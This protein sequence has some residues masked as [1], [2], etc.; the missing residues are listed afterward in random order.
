VKIVAV[1][2]VT[3]DWQ[4]VRLSAGV[5]DGRAERA[6]LVTFDG[7]DDVHLLPRLA[8]TA[9][10]GTTRI[11]LPFETFTGEPWLWVT[12]IEPEP[13]GPLAYLVRVYYSTRYRRA[14]VGANPNPLTSP[15]DDPPDIRWTFLDT[16]EE[17]TTDI[18]GN[19][20]CNS[21]GVIFAATRPF[22]DLLLQV[23]FNRSWYDP[24][25]AL[26]FKNTVNLDWFL[27]VFPPGVV[28]CTD[29]SGESARAAQLMYWVASL[30]FRIRS[31]G[32]RHKFP[33]RGYREY[34]GIDADGYP[35]FQEIVDEQGTPIAE[36]VYLDGNGRVKKDGDPIAY[37]EFELFPG[38]PFGNIGLP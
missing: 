33:D 24:L 7:T 3:E 19:P 5:E 25:V 14:G 35:R 15:L 23:R 10:D 12:S 4:P 34:L 16:E 18:Y 31:A 37:R 6:F 36:P 27:G 22:S 11:P 28:M 29:Y 32:W 38:A 26:K 9:N 8:R 2:K 30:Q 13:V 20:I 21:A 1:T 17:V